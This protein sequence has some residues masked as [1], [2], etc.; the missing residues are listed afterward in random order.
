MAIWIW[1]LKER[2]SARKRLVGSSESGP[3][4]SCCLLLEWEVMLNWKISSP[5]LFLALQTFIP[6]DRLRNA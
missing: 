3:S 6:D 4:L 1:W 5:F 2:V